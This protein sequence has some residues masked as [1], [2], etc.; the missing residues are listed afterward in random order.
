M[1]SDPIFLRKWCLTPFS[2][3]FLLASLGAQ[4]VDVRMPNLSALLD[5]WMTIASAEMVQSQAA[6]YP[7]RVSEYGPY[8]QVFL[9]VGASQTPK[10]LA[11]ARKTRAVLTEQLTAVLDSV[12]AM[13][14]PAGGAP[15][16]RVTH[17]IQVGPLGALHA[18]WGAAAPRAMDF[19]GPMDLAGT[20][21]ICLP[22]GFSPTGLPFSIQFAGRRLSEPMLCRIANAFEKTTSWHTQHPDLDA[23]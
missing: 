22:S 9:A 20:P 4:I 7:F 13:A 19:T 8:M 16:W 21:A 5:T 2:S 10:R 1:V 23:R 18:A 17:A 12:D 3:I 15:A 11:E 6:T 14:C